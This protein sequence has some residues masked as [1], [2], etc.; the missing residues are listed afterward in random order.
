VSRLAKIA[1]GL[2]RAAGAASST[3]AA[4]APTAR[5]FPNAVDPVRPSA[6]RVL[7]WGQNDECPVCRE[8]VARPEDGGL[9]MGLG[10]EPDRIAHLV[11]RNCFMSALA[12]RGH[13]MMTTALTRAERE[14]TT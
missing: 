5:T 11:P 14:G 13:P 7:A 8:R 6:R 10:F 2:A 3:P 9:L 4:P 12:D 1:L